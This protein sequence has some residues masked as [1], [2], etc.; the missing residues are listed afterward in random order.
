MNLIPTS[1]DTNTVDF[2]FSGIALPALAATRCKQ[3]LFQAE[4]KLS[5]S[6]K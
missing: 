2:Q 1:R 6:K 3:T 5:V 4:Y